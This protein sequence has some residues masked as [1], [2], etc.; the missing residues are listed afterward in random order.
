[1]VV[2]VRGDDL[3]TLLAEDDTRNRLMIRAMSEDAGH[4]VDVA[5][6]GVNVVGAVSGGSCDA[7]LM[8]HGMPALDVL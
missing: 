8:D 2:Q 6:N 5:W 1:M 7:A 4:H 3:L